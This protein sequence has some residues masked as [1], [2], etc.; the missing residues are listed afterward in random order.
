M[1]LSLPGAG[2]ARFVLVGGT[3]F[4]I[5]AGLTLLLIHLGLPASLA[6]IPAIGIAM[7]FT[8]LANRR[9]TYRVQARRSAAEALRYGAVAV[10]M[11]LLSYLLYRLF[12]N[13]GLSPFPSIVGATAL[14][15]GISYVAYKRLAFRQ[16]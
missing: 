2:F 3:A 8:W 11:A 5:D 7:V 12:L 4:C 9:F 6:R 16:T 15:T 10:T 14:Q 13:A 1:K